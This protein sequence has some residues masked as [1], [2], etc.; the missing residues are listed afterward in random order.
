MCGDV[1]CVCGDVVRTVY[2]CCV[3]G[4]GGVMWCVLCVW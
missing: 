4:G 2:V 3:C 1:V